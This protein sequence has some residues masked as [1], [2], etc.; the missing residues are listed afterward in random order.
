MFHAQ[1]IYIPI[2]VIE[3]Q[4][5]SVHQDIFGRDPILFEQFDRKIVQKQLVVQL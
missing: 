3:D 2:L 1:K 5:S 4:Q